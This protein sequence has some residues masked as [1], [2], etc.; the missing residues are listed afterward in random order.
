[1]AKDFSLRYGVEADVLFPVPSGP[2][3]AVRRQHAADPLVV[4][5]AGTVGIGYESSLLMLAETLRRCGGKLVIASPNFRSLLPRLSAHEAVCDLGL[6]PPDQVP[7]ALL[8]E[9]T[10]VVA[11]VQSYAASDLAAFKLNFPSK[12]PEYATLGLPLIVVAPG[13]SSAAMWARR[14]PGAALLLERLSEVEF[15][16][17]V[18]RLQKPCFRE[19]LAHGFHEA[20]ATFDPDK[21]HKAFEGALL[22]ACQN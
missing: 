19:E 6:L 9:G 17:A 7:A 14:H 8:R 10:N 13:G 2:A 20:A 21:I 11:V 4:G 22:R 1:M 18:E 15:G 3:G 16:V 12:L 5:F